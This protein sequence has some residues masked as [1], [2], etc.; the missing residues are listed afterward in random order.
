MWFHVS[1]N[2]L[3][4]EALVNQTDLAHTRNEC[5][6]EASSLTLE[7]KLI[8]GILSHSCRFI[9]HI[10]N[11][12]IQID[13][14]GRQA[15]VFHCFLPFPVTTVHKH[16]PT[17]LLTVLSVLQNHILRLFSGLI[18]SHFCMFL[19]KST[20]LCSQ[21]HSHNIDHTVRNSLV[22]VSSSYA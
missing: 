3:I 1:L 9:V 14:R 21:R 13:P 12:A 5:G 4:S 17:P 18:S 20:E 15:T 7:M 6:P 19:L 22:K 8:Y 16:T 11:H 10:V 2:I